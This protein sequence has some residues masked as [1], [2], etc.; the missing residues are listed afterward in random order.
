MHAVIACAAIQR[1]VAGAA[2]HG[3]IAVLP[4]QPII[5]GIA[6]D[7]VIARS[8]ANRIVAGAGVDGVV[9]PCSECGI[10]TAGE[11][12]VEG[13]GAV[14]RNAAEIG[15]GEIAGRRALQHKNGSPCVAEVIG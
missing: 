4:K 6:G 12:L 1:V 15:G 13:R 8:G 14:R 5:A 2:I 9:K 7:A 10:I 11:G 3:V